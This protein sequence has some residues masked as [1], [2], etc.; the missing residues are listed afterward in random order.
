M[1]PKV[2]VIGAVESTAVTLRGLV[3]NG[4]D[5]VGVLGHEPKRKENVSG[6]Y[7][8]R[9]LA[10]RLQ[11]PFQR[12]TKIN[13]PNVLNWGRQLQPDIV[14]AVGFSQ[15]LADD[16]LKLPTLGCIGFHPTLLPRGRGRAPIAW[17]ILQERIGAA[18]FF[19][20]TDGVDNGPIFVQEPFELAPDDDAA[21]VVRRQCEA[22]D[23]ALDSWLPRLK[24]GE[25]NPIPQ[26]EAAA[27]YFGIRKPEDG[28]IDWQRSAGEIDRLI[29]AAA[30]PH[31]GAY[32]YIDRQKLIIWNSRVEHE[33][34][35]TG[36]V[37]R[38]LLVRD[39]SYLIQCGNGKIWISNLALER[40]L[41]VGEKLGLVIEDEIAQLWQKLSDTNV[42]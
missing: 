7:D 40:T 11:I 42:S 16:W 35:I 6:L 5:V 8:L 27:S 13:E 41:K 33:M 37:G 23:S 3:R 38:V 2:L 12:F 32:S 14:F 30:K 28:L 20:M 34:P 17:I 31:P 26:E 21:A 15:L 36:V 39:S 24:L 10:A 1:N 4:L 19:L 25:W 9:G 29:K 22:I 18:N